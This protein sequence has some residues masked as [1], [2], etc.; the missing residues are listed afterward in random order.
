MSIAHL[1]GSVNKKTR[2][3]TGAHVKCV[4]HTAAAAAA[5]ACRQASGDHSDVLSTGTLG[6][7]DDLELDLVI[8]VQ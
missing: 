2:A 1:R 6:V 7:L 4:L 3:P 5:T 8:L